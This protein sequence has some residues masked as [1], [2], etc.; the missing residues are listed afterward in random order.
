MNINDMLPSKYLKQEDVNGET[1]V[2]FRGLKQMNVAREDEPEQMKWLVKFDEFEKPMILN[3]T[4]IKRCFKAIGDSTNEWIGKQMIL[5]V[6][7]NVEFAGK[8]TGG[9]R[10][11][12]L[13][14]S[15]ASSRSGIVPDRGGG[16]FRADTAF[17]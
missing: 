15:K 10:L 11:K 7:E 9:L 4:N 8:V 3:P 6:D 2:T 13:P 5:Y 12:P 1:V 14:G 16:S 17:A